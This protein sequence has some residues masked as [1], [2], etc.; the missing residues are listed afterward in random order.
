M[1]A[2]KWERERKQKEEKEK[3]KEEEAYHDF[4]HRAELAFLLLRWKVR[5]KE[6]E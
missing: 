4:L 2:M 5:S 1:R 6:G 3:E